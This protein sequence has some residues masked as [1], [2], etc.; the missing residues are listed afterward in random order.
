MEF[1]LKSNTITIN[2][3]NPISKELVKKVVFFGDIPSNIRKIINSR[4]FADNESAMRDYFGKRWK[5]KLQLKNNTKTIRASLMAKQEKGAVRKAVKTVHEGKSQSHARSARMSSY[6]GGVSD[7]TDISN[8][9]KL[10]PDDDLAEV[11]SLIK[12]IEKSV[13]IPK[14]LSKLKDGYYKWEDGDEKMF[15]WI[16]H[17]KDI[18]GVRNLNKKIKSSVEYPRLDTLI[19]GAILGVSDRLADDRL[20]GQPHTI[21]DKDLSVNDRQDGQDI[22]AGNINSVNGDRAVDS[23]DGFDFDLENIAETVI[24]ENTDKLKDV[25][26]SSPVSYVTDIILFPEDSFWTLKE[27]IYLATNIPVYRQYIY[28]IPNENEPSMHKTIHSIFVSESPYIVDTNN[29]TELFYGIKIDKNLYNNRENLRIKT[30]EPY[31]MIDGIM[32]DELYLVDLQFYRENISNTE[33]I[34]ESSYNTDVLYYGLFKKYFPVFNREMMMKYLVDE[35]KVLNEYPLINSNRKTLETK[36]NTEKEILLDVYNHIDSY[37]D[38][39]S[40]EIDL[41]ISEISY[42][43]LDQYNVQNGI[44]IRNLVDLFQCSEEFPFIECYNTKNSTKYRILK[45]Y[46]NQPETLIAEILDDKV[47][48][49]VDEFTIYFWDKKYHQLNRFVINANAS[50]AVHAKY[51]RSDNVDFSD[52]LENMKGYIAPIIDRLNA[53]RKVIF[54][55]NFT[56]GGIPS[57]NQETTSVVS[58]KVNMRW[59][60]IVTSQQFSKVAEVLE[61]FYRSGM[62]SH[63]ALSTITPNVI[64]IRMKKGITQHVNKFY[65]KKGVEVKDYYII[66]HDVKS[67]DIWNLRYGGK[68]INIENNLTNI[69]FE[70]LNI[71][72]KEFIRVINYVMYM[73]NYVSE[74]K[75]SIK[76]T[77]ES[78][79]KKQ[80]AMKKMK[81]LDPKLYNF[82]VQGSTKVVKYSRICQKKFRPTN[83]YN[84]EEFKML[85]KEKQSKLHQFINYT[86]GEPVWYE[87]PASLP[88]LGFI[89]NKHPAGFC[90]PKCKASETNGAKNRAIIEGCKGKFTFEKKVDTTG[91]L[92][93]GKQLPEGKIGFLHEKVYEMIGMITNDNTARL[94]IKGVSGSYAGVPGS[95][96]LCCFAEQYG[97]TELEIINQMIEY[98]TRIKDESET[99]GTLT[100]MRKGEVDISEDMNDVFTKLIEEVYSVHF[101][102]INTSVVIQNEILNSSNS[103]ISIVMDNS[104]SEYIRLKQDIKIAIILRLYNNIYPVL[105][106]SNPL[107]KVQN[108]G[109]ASKDRKVKQTADIDAITGDYTGIFGIDSDIVR[110]MYSAINKRIMVSEREVQNRAFSYASLRDKI[111]GKY[112]KYISGKIVK[113]LLTS[114]MC[115]GVSNSVNISDGVPES[116]EIFDRRDFKLPFAALAT[117]LES[118]R[119]IDPI[120]LVLRDTGNYAEIADNDNVIGIQ[121]GDVYCWFD[122]TKYSKV[123]DAFKRPDKDKLRCQILLA[124]PADVNKAI[125]KRTKPK[126]RYLFNINDSYYNMYI[127][128]IVK[129]EVFKNILLWRDRKLRKFI[130]EELGTKSFIDMMNDI[131]MRNKNDYYKILNIVRNSNNVARSLS[132]VLLNHD[133]DMIIKSIQNKTQEEI[134]DTIDKILGIIAVKVK[135]ITGEIGNTIV[136]FID[137]SGTSVIN[138]KHEEN[139]FYLNNKIKIQADKFDDIR[140]KLIDDITNKLLFISE[141]NNFNIFFTINYLHFI[142]TPGSRI[143]IQF[144]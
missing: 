56:T 122:N 22:S 24:E 80:S 104:C 77:S 67:A 2:I 105:L 83:I 53:N 109:Y 70:F 65:L 110:T 91:V 144:L 73:I 8:I 26:Y 99:L 85:S 14:Q 5:E 101:V 71:A 6:T 139:L 31:K 127:Y 131:K 72:D 137:Y 40:D 35:A 129:Y 68:N 39:Y 21:T 66:Y 3:I 141:I 81:A 52:S 37:Y 138:T 9:I 112:T 97:T 43:S 18:P 82:A 143:H 42:K 54:N 16:K 87:C 88:Y 96:I 100:E 119:G 23:F 7:F 69:T 10:W 78:V 15:V 46:K 32:I 44:F 121:L 93:F 135:D 33:A 34:L 133:I 47:Y 13:E 94:F 95:R 19:G 130:I 50:I 113:Y 75:T 48:K 102:Y 120:L 116:H 114:N 107:S 124:E 38:K 128:K 76:N 20:A 90:I 84:E 28:Q 134:E 64:N 118:F 55:P 98:L 63:R 61:M 51:L 62:A 27:K 36:Y 123:E 106:A 132:D 11:R 17:N 136:S 92:K 25:D 12:E 140:A 103:D 60:S 125:T 59:N 57:F 117:F 49:V 58:V 1:C 74:N 30:K 111:K 4:K 142:N 29:D 41:A 126:Q 108:E 79:G 45:Y 89:T 86:T 115:I